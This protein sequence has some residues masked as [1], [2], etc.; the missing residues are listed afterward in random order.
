MTAE[1]P[2][3]GRR[4]KQPPPACAF[5]GRPREDVRFLTASS[6]GATICDECVQLIAKVMGEG[7]SQDERMSVD[8][9][10]YL[11]PYSVVARLWAASAAVADTVMM[12]EGW[13]PAGYDA[14]QQKSPSAAREHLPEQLRE[15]VQAA[16]QLASYYT[17]PEDITT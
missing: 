1:A 13:R 11:F 7:L 9:P 14:A 5:C 12:S 8:A 15:V 16:R 2:P 10:H 4:S 6:S 17:V 3:T